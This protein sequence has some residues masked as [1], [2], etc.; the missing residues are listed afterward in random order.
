MRIKNIIIIL[1]V[2]TFLSSCSHDVYIINI[3]S[4]L[5]EEDETNLLYLKNHF[6]KGQ[7][8]PQFFQMPV[9][10]NHQMNTTLI[11]N[12]VMEWPEPIPDL[13]VTSFEKSDIQTVKKFDND[14]YEKV[15]IDMKHSI[16]PYEDD[17]ITKLVNLTN[18]LPKG[19]HR[20]IF[21]GT[22]Y[23]V[24]GKLSFN[25]ALLTYLNEID[26]TKN[27]KFTTSYD[28]DKS[29]YYTSLWLNKKK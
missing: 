7:K 14:S 3:K 25:Y 21:V 10:D 4:S 22:K 19:E 18:E 12:G 13:K 24:P 6:L 9:F 26:K 20:I 17:W 8:K 27:I 28:I 16:N 29:T 2:I 1:I 23:L 5:T 15:I 11:C